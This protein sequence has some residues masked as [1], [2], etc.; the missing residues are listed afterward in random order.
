MIRNYPYLRIINMI[1]EQFYGPGDGSFVNFIAKE[2]KA[3]NDIEMT[4]GLQRR[5]LIYIDDVLNAYMTILSNINSM[6]KG[7]YEYPVGSGHAFSIR[8]VATQV[9]EIL[10]CPH[11]HL[12][13]GAKPMREGEPMK[14]IADPSL[15]MELGWQPKY[16]LESGLKLTLNNLL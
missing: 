12:K 9:C 13:W 8:E 3:G 11:E 10:D 16:S 14:L 5:D 1:C 7:L 15:M 2:L 6:S 4:E